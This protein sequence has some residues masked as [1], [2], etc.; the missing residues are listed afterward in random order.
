[1]EVFPCENNITY[2]IGGNVSL[3]KKR[4]ETKEDFSRLVHQ[5][6]DRIGKSQEIQKG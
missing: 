5:I 4:Q 1:L 2:L 3:G 6:T